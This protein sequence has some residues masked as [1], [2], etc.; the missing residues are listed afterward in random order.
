[1]YKRIDFTKL[2]GL[3][4]YQDTLDFLQTSYREAISAV[5][6]AFGSKVIVTGI[7]DQGAT[8]SDGWVV[9]DGELMPFAG[10]LKSDRIVVEE[11]TDTEVFSDGSIQ[12]V[13]YTKR[14]KLGITGGF[15][16]ADFIRVDTMSAISVSL[17]NLITAH[18]N[19]QAA[20]GSHTHS[21]N[22]ITDKPATFT[23]SWHQH[24][25]NDVINKPSLLTV[26]YKGSWHIGDF[27]GGSDGNW[28]IPIPNVNTNNYLVAGSLLS[29]GSNWDNDNDVMWMVRN[30]QSTFFE[31][32][33][34][35]VS[36]N[37]QNLR[38]EYVL[39]PL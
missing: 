22:Q 26:L 19:L 2:E 17:K 39:I 20:F 3:A 27:G 30:K 29:I 28:L 16:L 36:G 31:L 32:L 9:I 7:T 11:L 4:T 10:G 34:R 12:T 1:M 33:L 37:L 35:Q 8:Y 15:A 18:N 23:P 6:K 14:A 25:W 21:W 13:Y 5:A 38:F 24:D